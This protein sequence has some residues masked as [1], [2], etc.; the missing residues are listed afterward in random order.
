MEERIRKLFHGHPDLINDFHTFLPPNPHSNSNSN[1]NPQ[2]STVSTVSTVSTNPPIASIPAVNP[3]VSAPA[4]LY[5][6]Y[7][8]F[9]AVNPPSFPAKTPAKPIPAVLPPDKPEI[10]AG[11]DQDIADFASLRSSAGLIRFEHFL[12]ICALFA[13]K[14]ISLAEFVALCESL[15]RHKPHI[16]QQISSMLL[17]CGVPRDL[18]TTRPPALLPEQ[19]KKLPKCTPSYHLLPS[20]YLHRGGSQRSF[21]EG[22]LLNDAWISCPIGSEN[23]AAGYAHRNVHAEALFRVE[24]DHFE[25]DVLIEANRHCIG[26]LEALARTLESAGDAPQRLEVGRLSALDRRAIRRLYAESGVDGVVLEMLENAPKTTLPRVL[27]RLREQEERWVK[28]RNVLEAQWRSIQEENYHRS[29]DTRSFTFKAQD[30]KNTNIKPFIDAI[31]N[32][33]SRRLGS[34]TLARAEQMKREGSDQQAS[35]HLQFSL[36]IP[37]IHRVV[38]R[39]LLAAG[40]KQLPYSDMKRL[41]TFLF[42]CVSRFFGFSE[43]FVSDC[44]LENSLFAQD[45]QHFDS[46]LARI[47]SLTAEKM[48]NRRDVIF[49]NSSLYAFYRFYQVVYSRF[50]EVVELILEA[51]QHRDEFHIAAP[52]KRQAC[53]EGAEGAR[54]AEPTVWEQVNE[55]VNSC[56]LFLRNDQDSVHF[57]ESC[58]RQIGTGGYVLYTLDKVVSTCIKHL[59]SMFVDLTTNELL[60]SYALHLERT[61][62]SEAGYRNHCIALLQTGRQSV[63]RVETVDGSVRFW[64]VGN[65]AELRISGEELE[66]Q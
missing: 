31:K 19:V 29:L 25:T 63:Y 60:A 66:V 64:L 54:A 55:V 65:A 8:K 49:G 2:P 13:D 32:E 46:V 48:P 14:V 26:S 24:D 17:R 23:F 53:L 51:S 4:S 22:N 57:E 50:Q 62:S 56:L 9:P 1:P 41:R 30:K 18:I 5:A 43:T 12:R 39:F 40:K 16:L 11:S 47:S 34:F 10:P 36:G 37:L 28:E 6:P 33:A 58:R 38:L 42:Y 7:P 35:P 20:S 59:H 27:K 44:E 52:T 21:G 45:K 3:V 15:F 61:G